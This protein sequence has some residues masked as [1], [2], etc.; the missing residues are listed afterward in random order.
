MASKIFSEG[1]NKASQAPHGPRTAP[2]STR[3][4]P[5]RVPPSVLGSLSLH[6]QEAHSST[7]QL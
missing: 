2:Y 1:D 4:L 5:H 7:K 6:C 3:Q